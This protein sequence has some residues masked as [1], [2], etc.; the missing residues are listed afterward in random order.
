MNECA[1]KIRKPMMTCD[2]LPL[3]VD[4]MSH[5]MISDDNGNPRVNLA[6]TNNPKG[7]LLRPF[8]RAFT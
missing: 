5:K 8:R 7:G 1:P 6:I 4:V 2:V 3:L